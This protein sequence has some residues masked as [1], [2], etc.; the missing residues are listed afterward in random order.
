MP[1]FDH[2]LVSNYISKFYTK[3]AEFPKISLLVFF[4]K[5]PSILT[6]RLAPYGYGLSGLRDIMDPQ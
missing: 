6:R 3:R 4:T 2:Q 1:P 5:L